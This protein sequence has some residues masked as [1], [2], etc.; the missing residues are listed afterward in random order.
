MNQKHIKEKV[1]IGGCFFSP[2]NSK[3]IMKL[4]KEW[5]LSNEFIKVSGWFA[6]LNEEK[7][8]K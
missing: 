8:I 6:L 3:H 1:N 7:K 5:L 2:L 4:K